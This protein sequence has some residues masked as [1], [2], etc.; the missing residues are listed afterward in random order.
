MNRTMANDIRGRRR[1]R[2][3]DGI[4]HVPRT[5][6]GGMKRMRAR[7]GKDGEQGTMDGVMWTDVY[8][9]KTL[10]EVLIRKNKVQEL[11]DWMNAPRDAVCVL[12]G[13]SGCG[14]STLVRM[15]AAACRR[16]I[17]EYIGNV[18]VDRSTLVYNPSPASRDSTSVSKLEAYESFCAR[19]WMPTFA[20]SATVV[21]L[22]D[23]P[24]VVGDDQTD[25]FVKS[26]MTL[27][28]RSKKTLIVYTG[29]SSKDA[30]EHQGMMRWEESSIPKAMTQAMDAV[31][32]PTKISLNPIP[33]A[34]MV[35]HLC[36]IAKSENISM[37]KDDIQAIAEQSLGDLSHAILTL[38]FAARGTSSVSHTMTARDS[39]LTLFHGL[40]KL[41]YNK[42]IGEDIPSAYGAGGERAP[43]DG[44]NPEDTVHASGLSG[45]SVSAFLHENILAFI[46]DEH[47]EDTSQCLEQISFSDVVSSHRDTTP[48]YGTDDHDAVRGMSD[49]V[50][51]II[52]SRGVCFWNMHPAPRTWK[53]LK[54]PQAFKV[55]HARR[56]NRQRLQKA[57]AVNRVEYGGSL[58]QSTFESMATE[59]VPYLRTCHPFHVHQQPHEWD[60]YWQGT[61][62]HATPVWSVANPTT[63]TTGPSPAN[64]DED[65][66]PIE[67]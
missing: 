59:I 65:D 17:V 42:R 49:L 57:A 37:P 31:Y 23:M 64:G 20:S 12:S 61:L 22:D 26:T 4:H 62:Y 32:H 66:D 63:K 45:P 41:L 50:A 7:G 56:T 24:I 34:T 52:S 1:R 51:S 67:E 43:M 21:V 46:D 44:F 6:G 25:R 36:S 3:D 40:G 47:I 39:S 53:P 18:Q 16:E 19:A 33:K 35:K 30:S 5:G 15:V 38:Q 54:A 10:N 27:L 13:P 28:S 9:P 60:R 55:E 8:A 2:Q 11:V 58:D 48:Y 14:K 29:I